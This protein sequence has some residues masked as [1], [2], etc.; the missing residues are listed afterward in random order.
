MRARRKFLTGSSRWMLLAA[1][2]IGCAKPEIKVPAS[3]G[4]ESGG[5][6]GGGGGRGGTTGGGEGGA[7]RPDGPSVYLP[8]LGMPDVRLQMVGDGG[9]NKLT[10]NYSEKIPSVVLLLDRS[11]SMRAQ[12]GTPVPGQPLPTRWNVLKQ[13]IL[14]PVMGL[15]KPNEKIQFGLATYTATSQHPSCPWLDEVSIKSGNY[16]AISALLMPEEL[17]PTKG[18]TPTSESVAAAVAKLS[19]I[20]DSGSKYIVLATDGEPDTCPGTCTGPTCAVPDKPGWPRDP[21][22][23]QDR[24]IAAV[25]DAFKKGIKTFVIGLGDEVGAEHLQALANA[26]AGL[27]VAISPALMQH[28]TGEC[29]ILPAD[30]KGKYDAAGGTAHFFT[31]TNLKEL[32]NDFS[33]VIGAVRS[34]KFTLAGKVQQDNAG[35][36]H[37]T[38][39]GMELKYKDPNGWQANSPTELEVLGS[40]CEQLLHKPETHIDIAFPCDVYFE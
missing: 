4:S 3:E 16:D 6:G 15:I 36:G 9:C 33:V 24:S 2:A 31:P 35:Q 30:L 19:E 14:D 20:T 23:G 5:R 38:L 7:E 18:E 29:R 10:A 40:A 26:G 13:A 11:S 17:P 37:V 27:P 32:A 21:S 22:C 1:I 25:Q 34:C 28:L 39:D 12:Y 8:D